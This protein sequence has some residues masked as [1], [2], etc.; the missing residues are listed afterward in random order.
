MR[1]SR[2]RSESHIHPFVCVRVWYKTPYKKTRSISIVFKARMAADVPSFAARS[3]NVAFT[4]AVEKF[5]KQCEAGVP[6]SWT[7]DGLLERLYPRMRSNGCMMMS[8]TLNLKAVAMEHAIRMMVDMEWDRTDAKEVVVDAFERAEGERVMK[9]QKIG[10]IELRCPAYTADNALSRCASSSKRVALAELHD[11]L[12]A[13]DANFW[14]GKPKKG[15]VKEMVEKET[16]LVMDCV[17]RYMVERLMETNTLLSVMGNGDLEHAMTDDEAISGTIGDVF[18]YAQRKTQELYGTMEG[19]LAERG[20]LRGSVLSDWHTQSLVER[21]ESTHIQAKRLHQRGGERDEE[22]PTG[23][24]EDGNDVITS[25]EIKTMTST[26]KVRGSRKSPIRLNIESYTKEKGKRNGK[27]K[28]TRVDLFNT[29]SDFRR[30]GKPCIRI[31]EST[32]SS[33]AKRPR[34][35]GTGGECMICNDRQANML[36]LPCRHVMACNT[37]SAQLKDKCPVCR[38]E[39]DAKYEIFIV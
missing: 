4:D 21:V 9:Q 25:V 17:V 38:S 14:N 37:C 29:Q 34:V 5:T 6:R 23:F 28:K 27:T 12:T 15:K 10:T 35:E 8:N 3:L 1:A 36:F 20:G 26:M 39:I 18:E 11:E 24:G 33:V 32:L 16:K 13:L 19:E 31:R 7:V 2:D 30:E 22:D